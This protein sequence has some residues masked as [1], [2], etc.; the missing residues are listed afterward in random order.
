MFGSFGFLLHE[1][2][3]LGREAVSLSPVAHSF[4]RLLF[5]VRLVSN[6]FGFPDYESLLTL[7][8]NGTVRFY[9]GMVSKG[10]GAWSVIEGDPE[11]GEDPSDLFIVSRLQLGCLCFGGQAWSTTVNH[12][13]PLPWPLGVDSATN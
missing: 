13:Q 11:E 3:S 12:G 8:D 10:L 5:A 2:S 6:V 4:P 9:A 1:N 7:H